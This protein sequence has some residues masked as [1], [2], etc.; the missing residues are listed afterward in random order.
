MLESSALRAEVQ[1]N[2]WRDR[3]VG[4]IQRLGG[5]HGHLALSNNRPCA[6]LGTEQLSGNESWYGE[7]Y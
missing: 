7:G 1:S 3:G 6:V 4:Q 5:L 2:R